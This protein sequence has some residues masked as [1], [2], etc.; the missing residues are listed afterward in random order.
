[1]EHIQFYLTKVQRT[2]KT[3]GISKSIKS[4]L[5]KLLKLSWQNIF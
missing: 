3:Q 4:L 2:D 5:I 1:M